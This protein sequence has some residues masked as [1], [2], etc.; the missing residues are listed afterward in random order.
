MHE[1]SICQALLNQ[2][3]KITHENEARQVESITVKIGLLSGIEPELLA[4][5]FS[6]A[7]LGTVAESAILHLETAPIKVRCS[8]CQKESEV[9]VNKLLCLHCGSWHTQVMSGDELLLMRVELL[10]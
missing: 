2:V 1:M 9:S 6:I 8:D 10:R 7:K 4:N 5:A 3:Q